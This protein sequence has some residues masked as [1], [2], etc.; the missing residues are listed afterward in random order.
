MYYLHTRGVMCYSMALYSLG[1]LMRFSV[2]MPAHNAA[3]YIR[4]MLDSIRMQ[5]FTDYE[6]IIVCDA[7]TDN[8]AEIARE[9]TDRVIEVNNV[10]AGLTRNVGLE[11]AQ[12]EYLLFADDDDWW[13]HE[14]AF[15]MIHE[16]LTDED[17]LCFGFIWKGVGYAHPLRPGRM[18]WPAVWNKCWKRSAI[19]H[20]RFP[21]AYPDDLLFHN[22][23][24]TDHPDLKIR[25]YDTPLYYYNYMRPGSINDKAVAEGIE[26]DMR[27]R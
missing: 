3:P 12:G 11:A 14:F 2:I 27:R 23:M 6:L 4:K 21:D 25:I 13:L 24:M 5:T 16:A 10:N 26:R 1:D 9:Y 18:L 8:T 19:G 22:Q 7:C 17:M 20:T 15:E